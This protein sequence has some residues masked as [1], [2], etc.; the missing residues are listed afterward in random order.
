MKLE[1]LRAAP[2]QPAGRAPLLFVHGAFSAAWC[3]AEHFL[4]YFADRGYDSYAVS[5]RGHGA[6]EGRDQIHFHSLRD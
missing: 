6:S 1:V 2:A 4:P 5:L 3:W